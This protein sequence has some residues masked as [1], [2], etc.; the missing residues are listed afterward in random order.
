MDGVKNCDALWDWNLVT[1]RVHFSPRWVALVGAEDH[2]VSSSPQEWFLRVHPEDN[3]L[4]SRE[5][6]AARTGGAH[7]F[8]FRHRMRHK[9]GSYRWMACSGVVVCD[10]AGQAIRLT[11][12]HADVIADSAV[13]ALTG[14]P[15]R[16]LFVE[17]L[18]RALDR[19]SRYGNLPFAVLLLGLDRSAGPDSPLNAVVDSPLLTA[20]ARRLE[21][22]LRSRPETTSAKHDDLVARLEDDHFAILLEGLSEIGDSQIVAD[23][24][25]AD[26]QS[27]ITLGGRQVYVSASI[28]IAVSV[29]G[30]TSAEAVLS[31][32]ETALH[33]AR[34][35]GGSRREVFDTAVLRSEQAAVRLESEMPGAL[36]RQEFAVVYQPI[37]SLESYRIVGFEALVR[38]HHPAVGLIAPSDFIPAAERTGFIVPLGSW[39]LRQACTQLNAWR[40]AIPAAADLWMSVNLSAVQLKRPTLIDEIGALLHECHVNPQAVVLE[41]TEGV[42]C[43]NPAAVKTALMQ[44]RALGIR[45][46]IDDFGTGYSSLSYLRQLPVDTLKVDRSFVLGMRTHDESAA[47]IGTVTRMARQLGLHVVAEGIEREEQVGLLRSLHCES[48]QGYLF[49]R[50]LDVDVATEILKTGVPPPRVIES[51]TGSVNSD[52]PAAAKM[53]SATLRL[54]RRWVAIA[55]AAGV[56]IAMAGVAN[57]FARGLPSPERSVGVAPVEQSVPASLNAAIPSMPPNRPAGAATTE[58][59]VKRDSTRPRPAPVEAAPQP[60]HAKESASRSWQVQ[61]LHRLGS[62]AGRLAVSRK[63]LVFTPDH[64]SSK[65]AFMLTH[66]EFLPS[67]TDTT[68]TIKSNA[69]TYRFR[70]SADARTTDVE[71]SFLELTAAIAKLR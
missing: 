21:T 38:W 46:S 23:R 69:K 63:G 1:N 13:D 12:S 10:D 7:A 49:A 16:V 36:E 59:A 55:A 3:A 31:D 24:V 61:H 19:Y 26:L 14:L 40:E 47:I 42:A 52:T 43:E 48:G 68:L 58:T 25:L 64:T 33:R 67:S 66:D 53:A 71:K 54:R 57:R 4:V 30:Y 34:V 11:G 15:S 41:L 45:I 20:V 22:C 27:P 50:P 65:D 39:V 18:T 5:L 29:T 44:L 56:I 51:V 6:D 35:L 8:E 32:A 28:G 37:V 60:P 9:N 2:E 70:V 17:R 62:C